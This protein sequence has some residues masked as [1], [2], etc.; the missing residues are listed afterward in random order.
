MPP[1]NSGMPDLSR[2]RSRN[3][4]QETLHVYY[5]DICVGTIGRRSG[6]PVGAD[7]WGWYC[8]F[9]PM[10]HRGLREDGTAPHFYKARS[11]FKAAWFRLLPLITDEDFAEHRYQRAS[12]SWKHRM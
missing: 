7:Q 9:F 1:L 5:S 3:E 2:R 4:H 12:T 11:Y 10:S 8:G 6:V